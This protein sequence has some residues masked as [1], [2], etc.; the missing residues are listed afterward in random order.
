MKIVEIYNRGGT[1]NYK[2]VDFVNLPK[3]AQQRLFVLEANVIN[4]HVQCR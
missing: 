3:R 2:A 4:E 1:R